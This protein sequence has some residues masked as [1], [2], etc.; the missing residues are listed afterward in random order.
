M[1]LHRTETEN[2]LQNLASGTPML[3]VV[4][5]P[6]AAGSA[7]PAFDILTVTADPSE[8]EA[9]TDAGNSLVETVSMPATIIE[10]TRNFVAEHHVER[11][12]RKRQRDRVDPHRPGH[13][14][15]GGE[16]SE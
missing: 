9:L 3:W 4:L 16:N 2:Y 5:Q 8:G 15:H 10:A 14:G 6:I 7:A 1:E 13:H 12:F 11:P